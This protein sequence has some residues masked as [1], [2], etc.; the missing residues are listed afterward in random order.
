MTQN[1]QEFWDKQARRYD[2]SEKQFTAVY[3]DSVACEPVQ[4][5]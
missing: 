3:A 5:R 4:H 1:T 2:D